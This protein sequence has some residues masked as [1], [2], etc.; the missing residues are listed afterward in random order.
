MCSSQYI[1]LCIPQTYTKFPSNYCTKL[2]AP[3]MLPLDRVKITYHILY[4]KSGF[5]LLNCAIIDKFGVYRFCFNLIIV[6]NRSM[7]P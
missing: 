7:T 6:K 1:I 2:Y 4:L 3:N 5:V